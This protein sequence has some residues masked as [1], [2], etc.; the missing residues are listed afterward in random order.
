[1][2][3]PAESHSP[4]SVRIN[5]V[6][7]QRGWLDYDGYWTSDDAKQ[8]CLAAV[9]KRNNKRVGDYIVCQDGSRLEIDDHGMFA[10]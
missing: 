5:T 9:L 6:A 10:V 8:I 2:S 4:T 3:V 7:F 1:M